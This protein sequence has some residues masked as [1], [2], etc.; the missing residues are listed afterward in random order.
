MAE[1]YWNHNVA[2]HNAL[3]ADATKRPISASRLPSPASR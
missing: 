2:F 3:V 1:E